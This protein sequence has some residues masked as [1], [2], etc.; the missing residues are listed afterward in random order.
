[1]E[2]NAQRVLVANAGVIKTSELARLPT[3]KPAAMP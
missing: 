2:A 3:I 1:M